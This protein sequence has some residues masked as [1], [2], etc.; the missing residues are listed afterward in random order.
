M[1]YSL[2]LLSDKNEIIYDKNR[3]D[4]DLNE[5]F[6]KMNENIQKNNISFIRLEKLNSGYER[7]A[8]NL[9]ISYENDYFY[10]SMNEVTQDDEDV[11]RLYEGGELFDENMNIK[12]DIEIRGYEY[13]ADSL[14]TD[15]NLV[16]QVLKEFYETGNVSYD[17]LEY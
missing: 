10:M 7:G 16:K 6:K 9:Q 11:V 2:L 5:F 4:I 8:Y 12:D 3:N 17:I 13:I 15:V 14:T 1:K